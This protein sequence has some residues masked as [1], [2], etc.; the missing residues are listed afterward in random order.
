MNAFKRYMYIKDSIPINIDHINNNSIENFSN[1]TIEVNDIAN[2]GLFINQLIN[3]SK[4]IKE[5]NEKIN[6]QEPQD[7]SESTNN[8][9]QINSIPNKTFK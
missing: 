3:T 4:S 1:E 6:L 7:L 8:D 9:N 5:P 2:N